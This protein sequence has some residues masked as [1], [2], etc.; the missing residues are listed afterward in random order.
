MEE[1]IKDIIIPGAAVV[2]AA[3]GGAITIYTYYQNSR[4]QRAQ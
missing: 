3:I 2:G 4:L 1:V